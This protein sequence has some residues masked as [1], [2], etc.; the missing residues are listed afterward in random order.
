MYLRSA[1]YM[2]RGG[3]LVLIVGIVLT[4]VSMARKEALARAPT[5]P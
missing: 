2:C 1:V 3:I 5:V 4:N